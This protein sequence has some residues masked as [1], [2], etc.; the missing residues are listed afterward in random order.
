MKYNS[1]TCLWRWN[2]Q[3]APKR[4]HFIQL[5][6]KMERTV[7]SE[8]SAI[9][10]Q[11]TRNYPKRNKLQ[12][13]SSSCLPFRQAVRLSI[14]PRGITRLPMGRYK[15]NFTFLEFKKIYRECSR[16]VKMW[17]NK[18]H[19]KWKSLILVTFHWWLLRMK[20]VSGVK[21]RA[22]I[23]IIFIMKLLFLKS[24]VYEKT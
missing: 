4:R 2:I 14:R 13:L 24:S 21:S 10:T 11:T 7:S 23:N 20:N 9:R 18:R 15:W 12:L 3:W 8:T 16:F 22:N 5:L 19:F 6:M 1:F 17:K